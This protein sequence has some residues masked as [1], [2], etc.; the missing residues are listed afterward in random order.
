MSEIE[1]LR[2]IQLEDQLAAAESRVK[3]FDMY[4]PALVDQWITSLTDIGLSEASARAL[5][6]AQMRALDEKFSA[7]IAARAKGRG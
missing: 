5:V 6:L 2:I 3:E 1:T 7:A 4:I